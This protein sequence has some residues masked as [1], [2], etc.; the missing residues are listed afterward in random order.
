MRRLATA[1]AL[2][3]TCVCGACGGPI[4]SPDAAVMEG[5]ASG[6]DVS[7]PDTAVVDAYVPTDMGVDTAI[8]VDAGIDAGVDL[9]ADCTISEP[10]MVAR[11]V[12]NACLV[13]P[14]VDGTACS[15]G[16]ARICVS[17]QCVMRGC[18]DGYREPG[19]TVASPTDF[20]GGMPSDAAV[21]S[22]AATSD[23]A[24]PPVVPRESCD[25]GNTDPNDACDNECNTRLHVAIGDP[26]GD[27]TPELTSPAPA[28]GVDDSGALL[29]VWRQEL[30][31]DSPIM[32]QRFDRFGAKVG[33]P[34]V[35]SERLSPGGLVTSG[36]RPTALGLAEGWVVGFTEATRFDGRNV[37]MVRVR[38]DGTLGT[39]RLV[40]EET[41]LE[42]R[43][44]Y[45]ARLGDDRFVVA[46]DNP[47]R[48]GA[49]SSFSVWARRFEG[50]G[51]RALDDEEF[52]INSSTA[53]N[54]S[55][56]RVAAI[57]DEWIAIYHNR[58]G[59]SE[60]LVWQARRFSG[61]RATDAADFAAAPLG[62]A[63]IVALRTHYA[64][65]YARAYEVF[66]QRIE[67]GDSSLMP[68]I[69]MVREAGQEADSPVI[70][71]LAPPRRFA[72]TAG[73]PNLDSRADDFVVLHEVT[74]GAALATTTMLPP[75]ADE[76][77]MH[78][79][80]AQSGWSLAA[81]PGGVWFAWT[82]FAPIELG[83]TGWL[84]VALYQLP[85]PAPQGVD[86]VHTGDAL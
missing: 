46:Y 17:A 49:D 86:V 35:L 65:V 8:V 21:L 11:C 82:G 57:G 84:S 45:M 78:L 19:F 80:H 4:A 83:G 44:P 5:D 28:I 22:D 71:P 34:I 20:D 51:L 33:E 61:A 69:P 15:E 41:V 52:R 29:V 37:R 1:V 81:G 76:L 74:L 38:R 26:A 27:W 18:G 43:A 39:T 23:A 66:A 70:A 24:S 9:C 55:N 40:H 67:L 75:E 30:G 62:S 14:A 72:P 13:E 53:G 59:G 85:Y 6:E 56:V 32:G 3:S 50:D 79:N 63:D 68:A 2:S 7:R 77:V 36:A 16:G 25:D 58:P 10:C 64:L 47:T 48:R 31:V 73:T 12:D 42:Q 54:Q 60:P